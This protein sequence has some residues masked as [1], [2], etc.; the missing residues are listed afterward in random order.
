MDS[1][2]NQSEY[3]DA[4]AGIMKITLRDGQVSQEEKTFLKDLA[5]KLNISDDE[6]ED[7]CQNYM[8]HT[9]IAPYTYNVRLE[10]FYKVT[11]VIYS[12]KKISKK[13]QILWLERMG[14]AMGFNPN[15]IE[16]IVAKSLDLF[17]EGVTME[18]YK[19]G[20]HTLNT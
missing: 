6:Y 17:K 7:I 1:K 8:S 4:F 9:I 15:N 16:Y 5:A 18:D 19:K 20:I 12:D 3:Y 10:N 11:E 2:K 13:N 14:V